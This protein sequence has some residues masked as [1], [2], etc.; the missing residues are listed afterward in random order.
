[1]FEL[2]LIVGETLYISLG[3]DDDNFI[4]KLV[5]V[6]FGRSGLLIEEFGKFVEEGL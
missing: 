1:L 2:F 4:Q 5:G 3:V 6:L